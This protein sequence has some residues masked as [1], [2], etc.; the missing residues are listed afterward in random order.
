[1]DPDR[2][3]RIE[4]LYHAALEKKPG[5][6]A[7]F[8]EESCAGDSTLRREV[9]S[10]LA[11]ADDADDYLKSVVRETTSQASGVRTT[12]LPEH[13]FAPAGR[14]LGRY[15]LLEQVGK[16][17]MGVVYRAV[18]PA[19]GRTVAIKTILLADGAGEQSAEL[20][21][22]LLRES[23]AGGQLSH[24]NIVAVYDVSEEG[25]TAYI[26]MEYVVGQTLDQ[27]MANNPSFRPAAEACRIVQECAR[28]LDYAHSRGIVH[29]DIKPGNIMLQADGAVKIA[30]FGIAKAVQFT[31]LTRSAVII[32]SPHY[33][34]PEQWR[35]EAVTGRTDQYA[36]AAVA[37]SLLTGHR[38]FEHETMA[39]IAGKTLYEEPPAA[40][41]LNPVLPPAVDPVLRKALAKLPSARYQTCSLFAGALESAC[42]APPVAATAPV[43]APSKP[44]WIAPVLVASLAVLAVLGAGAWLY[45][46]N[47]V[48]QVEIAYWNSIKDSRN[49]AA[50][51]AYLKR[52][53][54]GQFAGLAKAQLD[55][56]QNERPSGLNLQTDP[57]PGKSRTHAKTNPAKTPDKRESVEPPVAP[58]ARPPAAG[59]PYAQ[60]E[61]LSKSGAYSDAVQYFSQAIA[62]KPEY[63]SY[64]G[65][66]GAYQHLEMLPQAI[67]DYSQA[68]V[69]N[70]KSAMAYHE[71][72]VCLARMKDD[73]RAF[74]DYNR[75]LALAPAY[76][77]SLNGRGMIYLH[78]RDYDKA[79]ADFSA[80]IR[81][82]P[83]LVQAYENRAA[84]KMKL[85]D[86]GGAD[87]DRNEAKRLRR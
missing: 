9:E 67:D 2:W 76:P 21:V 10:L 31:P 42:A 22:R 87:A 77:L 80:A 74:D 86:I 78:R 51:D 68:I 43:V 28:A 64:F 58:P 65:R 38:P 85:G 52:F 27:A 41:A 13:D 12:P 23:Q 84:A 44:R 83:N 32:G 49:S 57:L 24:P 75:A 35:G 7:P 39:S 48:A 17:G 18:D 36:L 79:I 29:R 47:S 61:A 26:V 40:T 3:S 56:L 62:A 81:S 34:A 60:G 37:Y 50:Y 82:N 11:I 59:D 45:Q 19:I 16:G 6:R 73:A 33:M 14:K 8:L 66:A 46:R 20:R 25:D 53:P 1:M 5:A 71:R 4:Q 55:A 15:E 70:P 30:D 69:L 63:R 54:E 72:A